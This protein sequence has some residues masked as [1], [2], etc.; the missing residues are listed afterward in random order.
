LLSLL[1]GVLEPSR[2][3]VTI[4]GN[5]ASEF[6]EKF[7]VPMGYV[8]AEPFLLEGSLRENLLYG[9][10]EEV[11]DKAL[12]EALEKA[13]L[14]ATVRELPGQLEYA[15]TEN[16]EGL[17]T[18][19]KQRLSLARA[20]VQKPLLL[21]L[22]E[23]SANLDVDTESAI[24]DSIRFLKGEC[25]VLVISHRHGMLQHA[26][27]LIELQMPTEETTSLKQRT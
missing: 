24:A 13:E 23:A 27:T 25:T 9:S 21:F 17:S 18:G 20:L 10:S 5:D 2:G 4:N 3:R 7:D 15:L 22:D 14:A 1:L 11:E 6:F 8:G 19:Q 16:S 12:W 26:D